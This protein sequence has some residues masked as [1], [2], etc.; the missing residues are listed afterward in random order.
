MNRYQTK[1]LYFAFCEN[2][3]LEYFL[4]Q[5]DSHPSFGLHENAGVAA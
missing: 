5:I 4:K 1:K 3:I 2:Y